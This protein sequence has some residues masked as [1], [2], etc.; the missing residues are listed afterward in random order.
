MDKLVLIIVLILLVVILVA[1]L[2]GWRSDKPGT[3]VR[4]PTSSNRYNEAENFIAQTLPTGVYELYRKA[5]SAFSDYDLQIGYKFGKVG[6]GWEFYVTGRNIDFDQWLQGYREMF[7]FGHDFIMPKLKQN[8]Q[9]F[10]ISMNV[11]ED[12]YSYEY[13]DKL[14]VSLD[15][16]GKPKYE[17]TLKPD[18]VFTLRNDIG[19]NVKSKG[20]GQEHQVGVELIQKGVDAE[21]ATSL[22]QWVKD[23]GW[24]GHTYTVIKK[25]KQIGLSVYLP[26]QT[27]LKSYF[28]TLHPT[29]TGVNSEMLDKMREITVFFEGIPQNDSIVK[30]AFYIGL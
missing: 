5:S 29:F 10:G 1:A 15:F 4:F 16:N 21:V 13:V 22:M 24:N 28:A 25:G 14:N 19:V 9:I 26:D 7:P 17:Y 18:G 6:D 2:S 12:T 11:T 20:K 8:E 23:S 3:L 27:T 30:D